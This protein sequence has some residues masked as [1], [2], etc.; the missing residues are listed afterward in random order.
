M[1]DSEIKTIQESYSKIQYKASRL[2]KYFYNRINELDNDLDPLFA[3]DSSN[4]G[5]AFSAILDKA[6]K[7]IENPSA[8]LPEIKAMEAKIKYY[9]FGEDCMNTIGGAFIDTLSFGFDKEF[10]P[11]IMNPWVAGFKAYAALF[12]ND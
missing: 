10:T 8:L 11:P 6:V 7:S 2:A 5:A 12:F 3:E 9:K 4:N 1:T